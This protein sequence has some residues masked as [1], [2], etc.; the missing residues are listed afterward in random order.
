VTEPTALLRR[1]V[2]EP[3]A[4]GAVAPSSRWLVDALTAPVAARSGPAK[5]LEVGAG[6]GPVTRRLGALLGPDDLLDICEIDPTFIRILEETVLASGALA[7]ARCQGRVRLLHCRLQ[8]ISRGDG[9]DYI[10]AGLPLTG[11]EPQEVQEVL[12][13]IQRSLRP[14]GVFSYFEYVGLRRLARLAP[15]RRARRRARVVSRLL[16]EHIRS[17]EIAR[18]VVVRN[19]PPAHARHWRFDNGCPRIGPGRGDFCDPSR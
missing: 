9:Y 16:D 5:I 11:F 1:Y 15:Q 12:K 18:R 6:T 8:E 14:G 17:F 4:V 2:A 19:L 3:T 13:T 7:E 10:I